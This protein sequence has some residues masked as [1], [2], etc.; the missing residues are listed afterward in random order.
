MRETPI[1][2]ALKSQIL[3]KGAGNPSKILPPNSLR[4][5][6]VPTVQNVASDLNKT[7]NQLN[8]IQL[9]G[10]YLGAMIG[11][12]GMLIVLNRLG[13]T[14]SLLG[15]ALA[16]VLA[17][18]PIWRHREAPAPSTP[19]QKL[20]VAGVTRAIITDLFQSYRRPGMGGW[21]LI[22]AVF[23][24]GGNM[25]SAMFRPLLVDLG[26]SLEDI[27]FLLGVVG[28]ASSLLGALLAGFWIGRWGRRRA[29]LWIGLMKAVAIATYLL[30]ASG[31]TAPWL[32]YLCTISVDGSIGM[33][34]AATATVMMDYSR[35]GW[36][37][38]DY[39]AQNA[40]GYVSGFGAMAASGIIADAIGYRGVFGVSIAITLLSVILVAKTFQPAAAIAK[41]ACGI[42]VPD[43]RLK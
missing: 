8:T 3:G 14:W 19:R 23:I 41:S 24:A 27:G 15:L 18:I 10:N 36:A 43:Y 16:I 42:S 2:P 30:P 38:T 5:Q 21:L 12:G 11:G 13:W 25:A 6:F 9:A 39:T 20:G 33:G 29:L 32:L 28:N 31:V 37:G 22:L 1:C 35:L 17:L 34:Y 40:I 26:M 7:R 4:A